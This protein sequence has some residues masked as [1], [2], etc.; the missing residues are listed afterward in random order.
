M[1]NRLFINHPRSVGETYGEH[2]ATAGRFGFKMVVAGA[3]CVVHA[4]LPFVFARTASDT[5]KQLYGEMKARQPN[6]SKTPPAFEQP[7]WQIEYEI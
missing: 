7:E 4:A 2:A 6:F 1:I 5:V 3:A